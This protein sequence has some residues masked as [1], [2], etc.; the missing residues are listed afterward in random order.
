MKQYTEHVKGACLMFEVSEKAT[1]MV[2][3]FFSTRDTVSP[4]RIIVAGVG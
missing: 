4:L 3:E 1:E 2:K